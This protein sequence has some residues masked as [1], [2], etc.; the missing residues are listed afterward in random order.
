M[1]RRGS[2]DAC[3]RVRVC[4]LTAVVPNKLLVL[5]FVLLLGLGIGARWLL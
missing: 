5:V 2:C 4:L 1:G 3:T